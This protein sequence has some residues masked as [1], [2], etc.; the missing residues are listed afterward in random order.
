MTPQELLD[1]VAAMTTAERL[2]L[3]SYIVMSFP[4]PDDIEK[5]LLPGSW[6]PIPDDR[7]KARMEAAIAQHPQNLQALPQSDLELIHV[8]SDHGSDQ[9]G[10]LMRRGAAVPLPFAL[11]DRMLESE[12]VRIRN[13]G[14]RPLYF[15]EGLPEDVRAK[16]DCDQPAE[17]IVRLAEAVDTGQVE[18]TTPVTFGGVTMLASCWRDY[19]EQRLKHQHQAIETEAGIAFLPMDREFRKRILRGA[20]RQQ[21]ADRHQAR[22]QP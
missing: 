19:Y 7:L 5:F 16:I 22:I 20:D 11:V 17:A 13:G 12:A 15:L 9:N 6:Y 1:C 3:W 8:Q 10:F 14:G 4:N 18:R 2:K 21:R